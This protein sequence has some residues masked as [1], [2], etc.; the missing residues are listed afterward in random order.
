MEMKPVIH[1]SMSSTESMALSDFLIHETWKC[2]PLRWHLQQNLLGNY[3]RWDMLLFGAWNI[4]VFVKVSFC[5]DRTNLV[6]FHTGSGGKKRKE[7][8]L[9][10]VEMSALSWWKCLLVADPTILFIFN[11][12][13]SLFVW[14]GVM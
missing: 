8:N 6:N 5:I 1:T 9:H 11:T 13:L 2:F 12:H 7:C 4:P 3:K 10:G 14:T